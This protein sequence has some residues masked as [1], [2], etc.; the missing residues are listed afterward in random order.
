MFSIRDLL[1]L[2]AMRILL[3]LI[4]NLLSS[5]NF[6]LLHLDDYILQW[7]NINR[8]LLISNALLTFW[9]FTQ[10]LS[11]SAAFRKQYWLSRKI[12][13]GSKE[14]YKK[15][16]DGKTIEVYLTLASLQGFYAMVL[17][18]LPLKKD[19]LSY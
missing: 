19:Y 6:W 7:L 15:V 13:W 9:L 17:H 18:S 16:P 14:D 12:P 8:H 1:L 2:Q 3:S 11:K 10:P 4:E 5:W